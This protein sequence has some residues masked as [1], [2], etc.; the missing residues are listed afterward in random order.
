MHMEKQQ[1]ILAIDLGTQSM[2]VMLVDPSGNTIAYQQKKYEQPYFSIKPSFCEQKPDFYYDT[3]IDLMKQLAKEHTEKISSIQA[4]T[5]AC[6]RD[7]MICLDQDHQPLTNAILWLDHRLAKQIDQIPYWMRFASGLIGMR[8]VLEKQ[9]CVAHANWIMENQPEIWEKTDKVVMLSTYL[10]YRLCDSLK[11][12]VANMIGHIPFDFKKRTWYSKNHIKRYMCNIPQEKLIEL[13]PTGTI[14]GRL[15]QETQSKTGLG[16]IAVVACGSD[17]GCETLGLSVL[18]EN[19]A[20]LSFGTTATIQFSS[21]H[22]VEPKRFLPA[23]PAVVDGY[24]NPEIEIYRGYWLISWFKKEFANKEVLQAE[25]MGVS[26][27]QL[28]NQRLNEIPPGCQGLMLQPFWTPGVINPNAKGSI[29]GFSDVHTRIH[30]YRA[31]IEGIGFA[32]YD[33]LV[34][35]EKRAKTKIEHIYVCGG[36]SQ[37]DEILQITANMFNLPVHRIQTH[38]VT[39]IGA[40]IVGFVAMGVYANYEQAIEQMVHIKDTFLPD[41]S[42]HQIYHKLYTEIYRKIDF[43][44]NGLYKKIRHIIEKE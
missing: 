11:D 40:A 10:Q 5:L 20:A 15:N 4:I 23:Y 30:V 24:Y 16:E 26:P 27:E 25:A 29:I 3:M 33:G 18:Q 37:S 36:G 2:R 9:Y 19:K 32:L 14:L 22:Y 41:V 7:T 28:L 6:I 38:E 35:M 39:G 12:T 17:K 8:P 43:R 44:L 34:H 21:K 13:V 42:E 1:Y 31:I